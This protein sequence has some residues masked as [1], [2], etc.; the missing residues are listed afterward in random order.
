MKLY[1]RG[2]E[3]Q[4]YPLKGQKRRR[5]GRHPQSGVDSVFSLDSRWASAG[6]P[7]EERG[8]GPHV[9]QRTCCKDWCQ[10][11]WKFT[12][13]TS[14]EEKCLGF[15]S[16]RGFFYNCGHFVMKSSSHHASSH[17][18]FFTFHSEVVT[19][20]QI[21]LVVLTPVL[22]ISGT[23]HAMMIQEPRLG[24]ETAWRAPH[25]RVLAG[26]VRYVRLDL[27]LFN[28]HAL[29]TRARRSGSSWS[30]G[31]SHD[32]LQWLIVRLWPT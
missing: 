20:C 8:G 13:R 28:V 6:R 30:L 12:S 3:Q 23:F 2:T 15:F 27:S 24:E 19:T 1:T 14:D 5:S 17:H 9:D 7:V 16:L 4:S 10:C 11:D 29:H 31:T 26:A 25:L 32:F 18:F 21:D 22:Y